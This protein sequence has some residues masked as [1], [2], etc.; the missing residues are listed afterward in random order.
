MGFFNLLFKKKPPDKSG[1]AHTGPALS[2][3]ATVS[4]SAEEYRQYRLN[5]MSSLEQKYDLSTVEGIS[6]IPV[7]V[8]KEK[9]EAGLPNVTGKIE[10]YLTVKAGQF[11]ANN[12]VDLALACYRKAN[13]IM[14]FSSVEYGREPYMRLPR[15]LR[16]LRRFD[17]ARAEEAKI[18]R[19]FSSGSVVDYGEDPPDI[20]IKR[21]EYDWL[22]EF[23]PELCPKSFSAYSREK[24]AKSEKYEHLIEAAASLGYEID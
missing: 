3:H 23:L 15:Y 21:A 9:M 5:E 20:A 19:I 17:E 16:K 14:P 12:E 7:P 10:Y 22:W 4:I 1:A 18:A 11:A 8:R 13:E 24:I 2:A 6:A